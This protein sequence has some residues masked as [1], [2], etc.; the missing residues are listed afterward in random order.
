MSHNKISVLISLAVVLA[1]AALVALAGGQGGVQIYGL[2][3]YIWAVIVAFLIQIIVYIPAYLLR[4]E[5]FFDLTG[6]STYT[7]I[8]VLL[9]VLTP[10][11][12]P[13]S[14]V[15]AGMVIIWAIRLGPF[16]FFRVRKTGTDQRFDELK[17]D[18]ILF[19]RVW[20]M[21]GLW[22]S[23]TASAAWIAMS[24]ATIDRKPFGLLEF[25]GI[26][27]WVFGF[28]FEVVAD[29]QKS[30]FKAEAANDGRFIKT[31]LWAYS[32]HPNYFG[33]IVLWT[34]V[35]VV[36][37]PALTGWQWIAVI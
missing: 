27:L 2:P 10:E 24:S 15:L 9:F 35:F 36:A 20:I 13:R 18:P 33:E 8:T 1:V 28:V 34:G 7:L 4:S 3:I 21:Q 25:S 22:V 29:L 19:L 14:I 23:L 37:A 11:R 26:V 6:A 5:K 12:D 30:R 16:L 17:Q 32:R 31:G